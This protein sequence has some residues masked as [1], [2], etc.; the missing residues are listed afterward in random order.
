MIL[1]HSVSPTS[2]RS[3][4]SI[5]DGLVGAYACKVLG[6]MRHI[7]PLRHSCLLAKHAVA[8][9]TM[10]LMRIFWG[11]LVAAQDISPCLILPRNPGRLV[12]VKYSGRSIRGY[13]LDLGY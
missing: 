4:H 10:V 9:V 2:H 11:S 1:F 3:S 12:A 8:M 6:T 13:L 5:L 7:L